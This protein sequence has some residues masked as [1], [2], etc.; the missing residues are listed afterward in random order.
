MNGAG[1]LIHTPIGAGPGAGAGKG[2]GAMWDN[3]ARGLDVL[4]D[5]APSR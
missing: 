2:V 1:G 3:G 4:N 5:V